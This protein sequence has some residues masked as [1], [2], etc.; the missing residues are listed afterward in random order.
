MFLLFF[1]LTRFTN[2]F[3]LKAAKHLERYSLFT[4]GSKIM[5]DSHAIA[6]WAGTCMLVLN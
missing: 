6:V 5:T 4:M 3:E 1:F 2:V